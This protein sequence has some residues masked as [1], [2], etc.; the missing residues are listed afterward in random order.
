MSF[1]IPEYNDAHPG[2]FAARLMEAGE[3]E[4]LRDGEARIGWLMRTHEEVMGGRQILGTVFMPQ[5][6][7]RLRE[8]FDWLLDEK[9]PDGLDFLVILDATYWE[10]ADEIKREILVFHELCHCIQ[11]VD[12]YGAPR[13]DKDGRPVWGLRGHSVEEFSE[14]VQRYGAWNDELKE[15]IAAAQAHDKPWPFPKRD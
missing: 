9:F 13:F 11:K 15:F 4:H 10:E 1:L 12:Q 14:V 2:V 3:F 8:V 5:V 7:G 6:Q